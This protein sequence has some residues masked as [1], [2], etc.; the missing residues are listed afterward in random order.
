MGNCRTSSRRCPSAECDLRRI[1]NQFQSLAT[2]FARFD[3]VPRAPDRLQTGD[4]PR[5]C[6]RHLIHGAKILAV[7]T[8]IRNSTRNRWQ[9]LAGNRDSC[10][11]WAS[12]PFSAGRATRTG[13]SCRLFSM[14]QGSNRVI[15]ICDA[16]AF[17]FCRQK[18]RYWQTRTGRSVR[19]STSIVALPSTRLSAAPCP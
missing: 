3:R 4:L 13:A 7:V 10:F 11:K 1:T 14:R 19:S 15:D 6:L 17:R 18:A 12:P 8:S 2:R 16:R 5:K 9:R